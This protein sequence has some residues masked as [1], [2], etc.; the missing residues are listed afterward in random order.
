MRGLTLIA[1]QGKHRIKLR[2]LCAMLIVVLPARSALA[3]YTNTAEPAQTQIDSFLNLITSDSPDDVKAIN[4]SQA[5]HVATNVETKIKYALLSMEY[6]QGSDTAILLKNYNSLYLA[7]YQKGELKRA[8]HYL[9]KTTYLYKGMNDRHHL[10]TCYS[11]IATIFGLLNNTDSATHYINKN[12]E[13][14]MGM[15]DTAMISQSYKDLAEQLSN[16][17][18]FEESINYLKRSIALDSSTRDTLNYAL[19]YMRLGNIHY[20]NNDLPLAKKLLTKSINTIEKFNVPKNDLQKEYAY[21]LYKS[22]GY[23]LISDIYIKLAYQNKNEIYADSCFYFYQKSDFTQ[24]VSNYLTYRY[25]YV[26]YLMFYD[27]NDEA[28]KVLT[29]LKKTAEETGSL[30]DKRKYHAFLK[31]VYARLGNYQKAFEQSEKVQDL[32][33]EL[34]TDSAMNALADAKTTQAMLIEKIERENAETLHLEKQ[35]R[36]NIVIAALAGGLLLVLV[37]IALVFRVMIV[38]KRANDILTERNEEIAAQRDHIEQQSKE[39][40]ASINYARRIQRALLTPDEAIGRI[41]PDYF[42]LYKPRNVVSGDFYWVGQFGDNKVC[43]VADCTGHGV[44]GGFM[45]VLGMT[46]LNYIVG[47]DVMPDVILNKLREAIMWNLRQNEN[48]SDELVLNAQV[49]DGMDVAAFV[50]NE[51]L[52]TLTFAGANNPL[53]LIRDGEVQV[54][55][56]DRM[57]VGISVSMKP[58]KSVTLELRKGDCLYTYSDGFQDQFNPELERKFQKNRLRDLLLE[59]HQRPMPEQ[60]ELLN[61]VFREWRGPAENQTDD[62]V[63]MGVRI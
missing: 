31:D 44:P 41:F 20:E 30:S 49:L 22:Y 63:I 27:I 2:I 25:T 51:K 26:S 45:S 56:P 19:G 32:A 6:C 54:I 53:V 52:M 39:L 12:L 34:Y 60:R 8:L 16:K 1:C 42:L 7:N 40:R 24:N 29:N 38:R 55:K 3:Q 35:R 36:K 10:S 13:I 57:P 46:N 33:F 17:R 23:W 28:L 48:L 37:V 15:K 50:V 4:Y 58:F 21:E 61:L 59:I 9:Q 14:G 47:Q 18:F 11:L 43:I 5:G 62:V